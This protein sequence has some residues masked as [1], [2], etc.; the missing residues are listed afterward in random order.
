M[1][2]GRDLIMAAAV[3]P[4]LPPSWYAERGAYQNKQAHNLQRA[5]ILANICDVTLDEMQRWQV[6]S[7]LSWDDFWQLANVIN[8]SGWKH[9][10]DFSAH[11]AQA[12]IKVTPNQRPP[13]KH[14]VRRL[15]KIRRQ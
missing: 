15:K 3:A 14:P 5:N 8:V 4:N 11:L 12:S 9:L 7:G 10:E 13:R 6:E 2:T 1:N